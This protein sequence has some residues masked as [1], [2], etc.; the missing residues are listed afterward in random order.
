MIKAADFVVWL[1]ALSTD[2]GRDGA[3]ASRGEII[4]FGCEPK[5]H[6]QSLRSPGMFGTP[7]PWTTQICV[8]ANLPL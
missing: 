2:A 7:T 5:T 8:N 6:R 4:S 1:G 3:T